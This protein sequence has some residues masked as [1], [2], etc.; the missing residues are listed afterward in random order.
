MNLADM[1]DSRRRLASVMWC[2]GQETL[3]FV[4]KETG[5]LASF[6][7]TYMPSGEKQ[8]APDS[9]GQGGH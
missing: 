2:C 5:W 6:A 7:G 1:S 8:P 4:F 9:F 3:W